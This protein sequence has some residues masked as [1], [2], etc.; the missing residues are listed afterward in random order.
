M[1]LIENVSKAVKQ[2]FEPPAAMNAPQAQINEINGQKEVRY[3]PPVSTDDGQYPQ[4]RGLPTQPFGTAGT[5][6]FGGFFSEEYLPTLQGRNAI[7]IFDQMFRSNPEVYSSVMRTISKLKSAKYYIKPASK[8]D[9]AKRRAEVLNYCVFKSPNKVW[10]DILNDIYSFIPYSFSVMEP[11]FRQEDHPKYGNLWCVNSYGFRSQKTI[12]QW[13][14]V[15]E[16]VHSIRQISWGDDFKYVNMPGKAVMEIEGKDGKIKKVPWNELLVFTHMRIGNNLEGIGPLRAMY[17]SALRMDQY[18]ITNALGIENNARGMSL[19]GVDSAIIGTEM[20]Q[21]IDELM[22]KSTMGNVPYRKYIKDKMDMKY[23]KTDYQ[24]DAVVK[25]INLEGELINKVAGTEGADIGL[26]GEGARAAKQ[27]S[28][29]DHDESIKNYAM[30][31][32]E[33]FQNIIKYLEIAN[34]GEQEEYCEMEVEG[35][36]AKP[37]LERAQ[38]LSTL[39]LCGAVTVTPEFQAFVAEEFDLPLTGEGLDKQGPDK[40]TPQDAA[41]GQGGQVVDPKQV[42]TGM[43]QEDSEHG[44]DIQEALDAA[45]QGK[46]V[47]KNDVIQKIAQKHISKDPKA[48]AMKE[49]VPRRTLTEYERKVDF[50]EID[51]KFKDIDAEYLK[52]C[53]LNLKSILEQYKKELK[54]ALDHAKTQADKYKAIYNIELKKSGK[55]T[56][57]LTKFLVA[58]V[59]DARKQ[60]KS[61]LKKTKAFAESGELPSGVFGWVKVKGKVA[62]DT[63][64]QD[65]YKVV[66]LQAINRLDNGRDNDETVF[67]TATIG[68]EFIDNDS[69][70]GSG[71]LTDEAINEGRWSMFQEYKD[72]IRGFQFSALLEDTCN[73]CIDL[74]GDTFEIGD[75]DSVNLTPP[76]H[77]NCHCILIPI[78]MDEEAPDEWTGLESDPDLIEKHKIL[79]EEKHHV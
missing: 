35:I 1:G 55:F 39:V 26:H 5:Q 9:A 10:Q 38:A 57:D 2:F 75:P 66:T 42:M 8:D 24:S 20:D 11:T 64:M 3:M 22:I 58:T 73:L 25:S 4:L 15:D 6:K 29:S 13:Y 50:A 70:L 68:D 76:L 56:D 21:Q 46:K 32:C 79:H 14:T 44:Q 52:L 7:M 16:D 67:D 17:G 27:T 37:N 33:K 59:Q 43:K 28:S 47:N 41:G 49:F 65:L 61:E 78:T 72:Q 74:D 19:V 77:P 23:E 71:I 51:R 60:A 36:D 54:Y 34:F 45:A 31:V 30:Y 12:W 48:Y 40:E 63:Q 62:V 69:K 18:H 53:R